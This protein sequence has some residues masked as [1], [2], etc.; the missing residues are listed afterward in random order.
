MN[1]E[2]QIQNKGALA[3]FAKP[4]VENEKKVQKEEW[5]VHSFIFPVAQWKNVV[6]DQT[7]VFFVFLKPCSAVNEL[8]NT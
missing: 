4:F 3:P 8:S 6:V 1:G 7:C 5:T 2:S